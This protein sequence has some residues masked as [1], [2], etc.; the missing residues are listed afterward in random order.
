[1]QAQRNV[2]LAF[3]LNIIDSISR[4][5]SP[6]LALP[7]FHAHLPTYHQH[8]NASAVAVR[9]AVNEMGVI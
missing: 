8:M 9:S 3:Q 6:R 5:P 4:M 7:S 1:M 2:I